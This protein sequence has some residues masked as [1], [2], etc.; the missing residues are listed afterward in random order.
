MLLVSLGVNIWNL[1]SRL[2]ADVGDKFNGHSVTIESSVAN[3][4]QSKH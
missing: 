2:K 1:D 3:I 4:G